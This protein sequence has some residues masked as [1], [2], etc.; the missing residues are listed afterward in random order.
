MELLLRL[1]GLALFRGTPGT[2]VV[3]TNSNIAIFM[4]TPPEV[5]GVV[6]GI[7][8]AVSSMTYACSY[9]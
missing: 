8:N 6:G 2:I 1:F 4:N 7:F 5:A 3:Y 9:I